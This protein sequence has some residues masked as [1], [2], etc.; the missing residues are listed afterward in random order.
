MDQTG[1]VEFAFEGDADTWLQGFGVR[2]KSGILKYR[3]EMGRKGVHF[4]QEVM[5]RIASWMI[6]ES[7]NSLIADQE[8]TYSS[9]SILATR[10]VVTAAENLHA[11]FSA[12]GGSRGSKVSYKK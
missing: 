12:E 10:S 7:L 4:L 8:V 9:V 1:Q 11:E 6:S 2:H 3:R 5:H